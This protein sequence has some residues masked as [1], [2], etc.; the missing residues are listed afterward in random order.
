MTIG[1]DDDVTFVLGP[2]LGGNGLGEKE[3]VLVVGEDIVQVEVLE[4]DASGACAGSGDNVIEEALDG[5][6]VCYFGGLVSGEVNLIASY[7][8]ADSVGVGFLFSEFGHDSDVCGLFAWRDVVRFDEGA[9]AGALDGVL[10]LG[11]DKS[12]E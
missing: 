5:D 11:A 7:G 2:K 6:K 3:D 1:G 9:R 4:V 12:L 10:R 8:T